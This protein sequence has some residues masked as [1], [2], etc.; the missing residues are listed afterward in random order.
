MKLTDI[1]KIIS[2]VLITGF[3]L[4]A[5]FVAA[6]Q[7]ERLNEKISEESRYDLKLKKY[8]YWKKSFILELKV[9]EQDKDSSH[10]KVEETKSVL[11]N[12]LKKFGVEEVTIEDWDKP[13]DE[14]SEETEE[15]ENEEVETEESETAGDT[16]LSE[17]KSNDNVESDEDEDENNGDVL[18]EEDEVIKTNAEGESIETTDIIDEDILDEALEEFDFDEG[19]E[20]PEELEDN[21]ISKFIKVTV[22]TSKDP[23]LVERIITQR[24]YLR[25]MTRKDDVDFTDPTDQFTHLLAENYDRTDFTRHYFRN[26]YIA[27]LKNSSGSDSYFAIFKTWPHTAGRFNDFLEER[28]GESVGIANDGLIIPYEIPQQNPNAT[29]PQLFAVGLTSDDEEARSFDALYNSGV[30]PVAYSLHS[31]EDLDADI[32]DID[33]MQVFLASIAGILGV[34]AFMYFRKRDVDELARFGLSGLFVFAF[35]FALL[36]ITLQ[37]VDLFLISLESMVVVFLIKKLSYRESQ[38]YVIS[39]GVLVLSIILTYLSAGYI[40]VFARDLILLVFGINAAIFVADFYKDNI[41]SLLK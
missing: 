22:E 29:G 7:S 33:H 41:K 20:V 34:A 23:M 39:V 40:Q 15:T 9:K 16:E 10:I 28:A 36:K 11:F 2:I 14:E 38:R 26:I 21:T 37:P 5:I 17:E 24:S 31:S 12:R 30:I 35:W 13:E 32:I 27:K 8:D 4:T 6:P 25:I 19:D 18:G 3:T 1:Y